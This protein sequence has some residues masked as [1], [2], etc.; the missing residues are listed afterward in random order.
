MPSTRARSRNS[1]STAGMPLV[2][3]TEARK[4]STD[5]ASHRPVCSCATSTAIA[6]PVPAAT[7]LSAAPST[8]HITPTTRAD[9]ERAMRSGRT[10]PP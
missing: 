4:N 8:R 7:G 10:G 2:S 9:A 5:M 6:M 3:A 1:D